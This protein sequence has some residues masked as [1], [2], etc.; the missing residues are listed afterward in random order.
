MF[1]GS[2]THPCSEREAIEYMMES[3]RECRGG[4][5]E[6]FNR[7][8]YLLNNYLKQTKM[9]NSLNT[10][11]SVPESLK[12]RYPERELTQNL[13]AIK[14]E[15]LNSSLVKGMKRILLR[16]SFILYWS[17]HWYF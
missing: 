15:E 8:G 14:C 12:N 9:S 13:I 17:K 1:L 11:I 4:V 3:V 10:V 7:C 16:T 6:N 5:S 2:E